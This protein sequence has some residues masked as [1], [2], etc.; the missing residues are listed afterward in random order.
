MFRASFHPQATARA[1]PTSASERPT[2]QPACAPRKAGSRPHLLCC[3]LHLKHSE[4]CSTRRHTT[5]HGPPTTSA[6]VQ[7]F[8]TMLPTACTPI[9]PLRSEE[10]MDHWMGQQHQLRNRQQGMTGIHHCHACMDRAG[11]EPPGASHPIHQLLRVAAQHTQ[12]GMPP[13]HRHTPASYTAAL[14]LLSVRVVTGCR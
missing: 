12:G 6:V 5:A 4:G 1:A 2:Q 10:L 11:H 9:S 8:N 14:R 13:V 7:Q 3:P